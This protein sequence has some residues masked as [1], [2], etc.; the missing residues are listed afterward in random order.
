MISTN[1]PPTC[2]RGGDARTRQRF[3]L[4]LVL[5]K[6]DLP[7]HNSEHPLS[8]QVEV[9]HAELER[10]LALSGLARSGVEER[11]AIGT[12]RRGVFKRSAIVSRSQSS[13]G[14]TRNERLHLLLVKLDPM[15]LRDHLFLPFGL[16]PTS[17]LYP[18]Q[19]VEDHVVVLERHERAGRRRAGSN[20]NS[21]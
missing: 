1:L 9:L 17:R 2:C 18:Q 20:S 5:H 14:E 12:Y 4:Q 3:F 6:Q 21:A 7:G 8:A 16:P 19:S 10:L 11:A 13:D 15:I